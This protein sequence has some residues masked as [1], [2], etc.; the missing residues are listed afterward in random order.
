MKCGMPQGH[1]AWAA[2]MTKG[3][4]CTGNV[5]LSCGRTPKWY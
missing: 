5:A 1:A 4:N 2:K 3:W